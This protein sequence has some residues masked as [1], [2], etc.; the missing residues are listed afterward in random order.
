VRAADGTSETF[1]VDTFTKV[2]VRTAGHG[3]A[4]AIN[5]VA[6]GDQ[7][8]VAGTGTSTLTAKHIIVIKK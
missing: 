1:V 5:D 8:F 4:G 6:K 2:R 3:A 7:A